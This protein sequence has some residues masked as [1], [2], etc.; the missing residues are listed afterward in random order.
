[1]PRGGGAGRGRGAGAEPARTPAA[2]SAPQHRPGPARP[3]RG[4]AAPSRGGGARPASPH[5]AVGVNGSDPRNGKGG[6]ENGGSAAGLRSV[7]ARFGM[8]GGGSE[9]RSAV[10]GSSRCC[11]RG[12]SAAAPTP[13][14]GRNHRPHSGARRMHG[15]SHSEI[16]PVSNT[17]ES[18]RF[19]AV[20]LCRAFPGKSYWDVLFCFPSFLFECLHLGGLFVCFRAAE[21]DPV[22]APRGEGAA[23]GET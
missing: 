11:E 6:G 16:L 12:L 14:V 2:Q 1:M 21:R 8:G 19:G 15:E 23:A 20:T 10:G 17:M 22:M 4:P 3:E 13:I 18:C 7:R 5:P 9:R